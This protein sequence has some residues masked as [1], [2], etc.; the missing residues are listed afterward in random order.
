MGDGITGYSEEGCCEPHSLANDEGETLAQRMYR[1]SLERAT[2]AQKV[3]VDKKE[4]KK[5]MKT[6]YHVIL[7]NR[8]TEVIDFK[9]IVPAEDALAA[10]MVAAQKLGAYD[11]DVHSTVI[12]S[13][14]NSGYN[15]IK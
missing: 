7:F 10:G 1:E 5:R 12:K 2:R 8:K 13:I 3:I 11:P 4:V 14:D 9:E 6:L 15:P